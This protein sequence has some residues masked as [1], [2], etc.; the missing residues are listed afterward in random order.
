MASSRIFLA[1][2]PHGRSDVS[3]LIRQSTPT[4]SGLLAGHLQLRAPFLFGYAKP[5][6]VNFR[7]LHRRDGTWCWSLRPDPP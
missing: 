6:P 4:P 5:V 2:I 1:T 7:K 3:A